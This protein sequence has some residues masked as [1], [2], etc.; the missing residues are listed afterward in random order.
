MARSPRLDL[1]GE[2][3]HVMNRGARRAPIFL[4]DDDCQ[5]FLDL[6]GQLPRRFGIEVHAWSLMPNHFHLLVECPTGGLG[7]SLQFLQA[8]FSARMNRH[9]TWDGPV[10]KG[11]YRNRVVRSDPYWGYLFA[12]V[13][14]N[15]VRA[16]LVSEASEPCWTSH[17]AYLG[18]D[19]APEWLAT[20]AIGEYW[21]DRASYARF[22][23]DVQIG[24][25]APPEGFDADALWGPPAEA[26]ASGVKRWPWPLDLA[27]EAIQSVTVLRRSDLLAARPGKG[28]GNPARD[29]A[30]WWL[31]R[32]TGRSQAAI[33][34]ELGL[35]ASE[36]SRASRR[37][38][39][40][41]A[42]AGEVAGWV[43]RLEDLLSQASKA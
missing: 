25:E 7:R 18:L 21:P 13:H 22:I 17:R 31:P 38:R 33:G 42:D 3:H 9:H 28:G 30:L 41:V 20:R 24:R 16:R 23:E 12:Y 10:F 1:P 19:P 36:I 5:A 14:L 11:R 43:A 40:R 29:L 4:Q 39:A 2:R 27:F 15:P 6:L 34:R 35:D 26:A 37:T 8:R 32:A